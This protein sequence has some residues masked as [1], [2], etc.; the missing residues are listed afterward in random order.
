M[1]DMQ[2]KFFEYLAVLQKSCVENCMAKHGISDKDTES[3]MYDVTYDVITKMLE[4]IDGYSDYSNDR[5]DIVN[6]A[7]GERLKNDPFIELHDMTENY[8]K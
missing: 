2:K 7:T 1:N 4:M 6:T 8:L 5:H 3:L